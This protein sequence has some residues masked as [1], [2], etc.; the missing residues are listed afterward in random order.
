MAEIEQSVTGWFHALRSGDEDAAKE[1]WNRYFH[2]LRG[3]A[4]TQL[5]S[6]PAYDDEDL[7]LSVFDALCRATRDGRYS[8]VENRESLWQ[9]MVTMANHKAIDRHRKSKAK[10]RTAPGA[11]ARDTDLDREAT[12]SSDDPAWQ[13]ALADQ[14]QQLIEAL[15]E[16]AMREIA[17][18]KLDD[19]NNHEIADQLK[20]SE[21]TVRRTIHLIRRIW[22]RELETNNE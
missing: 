6:S 15:D 22:E 11:A 16:G 21:R 17:M 5:A 13:V 8:E 2:R 9:L 14:C 20:I 4:K 19:Y 7:A 1:L 12:S 10:S 18:L 3:F